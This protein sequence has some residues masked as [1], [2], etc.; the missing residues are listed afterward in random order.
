[1]LT[2]A[3]AATSSPP[4]PSVP[5]DTTASN[6]TTNVSSNIG[7]RSEIRNSSISTVGGHKRTVPTKLDIE[8]VNGTDR[9][10]FTY[11]FDLP[12]DTTKFVISRIHSLD[13]VSVAETKG[14]ENGENLKWDTETAAPSVTVEHTLDNKSSGGMYYIDMPSLSGSIQR[15]NPSEEEDVASV[16]K[17]P[18][19]FHL[20][21]TVQIH[22]EGSIVNSVLLLGSYSLYTEAADGKLITMIVPAE[23]DMAVSPEEAIAAIAAT[24]RTIQGEPQEPTFVTIL[25]GQRS[26][27]GANGPTA[28]VHAGSSLS[29]YIHEAAHMNEDGT[30]DRNMTWFTEAVATYYGSYFEPHNGELRW[31]PATILHKTDPDTEWPE[32]NPHKDSTLAKID[33]WRD[34][35][36]YEKGSRL[37]FALDVKIREATDGEATIHDVMRRINDFGHPYG[38]I[39]YVHFRQIIVDL[40]GEETASWLDPYVL[41]SQNPPQPNASVF[42]PTPDFTENTT[43]V[44]GEAR[45]T[46]EFVIDFPTGERARLESATLSFESYRRTVQALVTDGNDD[47][48]VTVRFQP[49]GPD[50]ESVLETADPAD[51]ITVT[52]GTLEDPILHV[53][54][55]KLIVKDSGATYKLGNRVEDPSASYTLATRSLNIFYE[56]TETPETE[57]PSGMVPYISTDLSI[58]RLQTLFYEL[59]SSLS[60]IDRIIAVTGGLASILFFIKARNAD[61]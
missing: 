59:V 35:T 28:V 46:Y 43:N 21:T 39:N 38:G 27:G 17:E 24:D 56:P 3:V 25:P 52:K 31:R 8:R 16:Y 5:T 22:G 37:L 7:D 19:G 47:G 29:I 55:L 48:R 10:Q 44:S 1:M 57:K 58:D 61:Q 32:E 49:Y 11:T 20:D 26:A 23:V 6:V 45:E 34:E 2:P 9:V 13:G 60:V 40:A 50:G 53:E 14:F 33:T 51:E 4:A 41:T 18:V 15:E 54:Q 36:D 30:Y 12:A 42:G